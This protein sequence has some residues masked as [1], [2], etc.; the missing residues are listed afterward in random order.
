MIKEA[1]WDGI[2]LGWMGWLLVIIGFRFSKSA[3]GAHKKR[4]WVLGKEDLDV[5]GFEDKI[6]L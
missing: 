3:F 5:T 1:L 6:Y 4:R 2:G